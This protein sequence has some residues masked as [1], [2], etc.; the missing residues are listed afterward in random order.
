M[1]APHTNAMEGYFETLGKAGSA[2]KLAGS[3]LPGIAY[4]SV[5]L[6]DALKV[7]SDV[8]ASFKCPKTDTEICLFFA[9]KPVRYCLIFPLRSTIFA[10]YNFSYII[11][12]H[13]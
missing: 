4:E 7:L 2:I 13:I 8:P 1:L 3:N 5:K 11:F 9:K 12:S 10:H 6:M